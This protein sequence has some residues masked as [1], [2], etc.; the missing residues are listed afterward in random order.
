MAEGNRDLR[1]YGSAYDCRDQLPALSAW[2]DD[3]SLKLLPIW[4]GPRFQRGEVYFDLDNP[5]RGAFLA[6]GEERQPSDWTYVAERDVPIE[7]WSQ[8]VT[9]QQP[10]SE[11]QAESLAVEVGQF[12]IDPN[13]GLAGET[14]DTAGAE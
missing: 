12:R 13:A 9:W 10:V 7:V 4:K 14:E 3:D 8:L 6:T 1:A 5:E 11:D 2:M